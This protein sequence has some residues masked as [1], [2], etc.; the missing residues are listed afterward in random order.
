MGMKQKTNFPA[1]S[2]V[3]RVARELQDAA[4]ALDNA[5]YWHH[6]SQNGYKQALLKRAKQG[7]N[8]AIAKIEALSNEVKEWGQ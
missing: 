5:D 6:E 3:R 1:S 8:E 7:L 2:D 4:N